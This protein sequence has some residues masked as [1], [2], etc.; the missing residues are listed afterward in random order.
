[1]PRPR[2]LP[3]PEKAKSTL[4]HRLTRPADRLRQFYTKFGMRSR[5]VFLVWTVWGG[6]ERGEGKETVAV[7]FELLPTPRVN[8]G[9]A[10]VRRPWSI[11]TMPEGSLIVDQVSAGAY[12]SDNLRGL[13]I[14][15]TT[16]KAPRPLKG[17]AVQLDPQGDPVSRKRVDFYWE[18]VE[19]GRG[20]SPAEALRFRV[21]GQPWRKEGSLYWSVALERASEDPNRNHTSA[22][23]DYDLR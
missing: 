14:P 4:A 1:M 8:D 5:R 18:V 21:F 11:G 7:R 16:A 13:V 23:G 22:A 10:I 6:A 3:S 17:E 19:D 2:P 20:D 12:T 15:S 9:T